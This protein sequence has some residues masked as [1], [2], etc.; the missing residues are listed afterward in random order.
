MRIV[1]ILGHTVSLKHLETNRLVPLQELG[2]DGGT[3]SK[4]MCVG[5]MNVQREAEF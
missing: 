2:R 1:E 3:L 4:E 5:N